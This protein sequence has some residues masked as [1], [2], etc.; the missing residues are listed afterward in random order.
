MD[1]DSLTDRSVADKLEYTSLCDAV[2]KKLKKEILNGTLRPGERLQ[3]TELAKR[4]GISR[5]PVRDALKKLESEGL[6]TVF[7]ERGAE[8]SMLDLAG[9]QEACRIAEVLEVLAGGLA[10]RNVTEKDVEGLGRVIEEMERALSEGDLAT[11]FELDLEFHR[12]TLAPCESPRLLKMI[13]GL[14]YAMYHFRR[15]YY[16]L[17]G[18]AQK[19]GETHRRMLSAIAARDSEQFAQLIRQ[20]MLESLPNIL[21]IRPD[22][23]K[24]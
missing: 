16:T 7:P 23:L 4:F 22:D 9:L 3:Q 11:W 17:P 8:V 1:R 20:H 13:T 21:E 6:V 12:R 14:W 5:M 24:R 2:F 15:G 10:I 19:A 18:K